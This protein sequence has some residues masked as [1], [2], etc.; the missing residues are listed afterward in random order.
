MTKCKD[1]DEIR[2][3]IDDIDEEI[4]KLIAQRSH[5]V[6]AAASFKKDDEEVK[7]SER[8]EKVI[9]K[10]RKIAEENYLSPDLVEYV[11]RDMIGAFITMELETHKEINKTS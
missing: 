6:R 9:A 11:Y 10:V 8:V 7:A 3:H 4:V 1:L 2:R 5:Y